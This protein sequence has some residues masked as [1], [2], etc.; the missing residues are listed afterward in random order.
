MRLKSLFRMGSILCLVLFYSILVIETFAVLSHIC[1]LW[2]PQSEFTKSLGSFDPFFSD[3]NLH[4]NQEPNLYTHKSFIILSLISSSSL[5]LLGASI[6][7]YMHKLLRNVY[8]DSFFVRENV[9][10]FFK[11]GLFTMILGTLSCYTESLMLTQTIQELEITNAHM[12][13]TDFS[14]IDSMVSGLIL[15][16]I[17]A[18]LKTAVHAVEENKHTI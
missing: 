17:S 16:I 8:R 18:A 11:L 5:L 10:I 13:I 7:W 3:I 9:S 12:N 1:Y 15:I 14:Y 6:A 2:F 4:F